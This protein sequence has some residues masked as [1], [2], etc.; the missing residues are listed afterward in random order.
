MLEESL[1]FIENASDHEQSDNGEYNANKCPCNNIH[2]VVKIITYPC[3]RNPKRQNYDSKLNERSEK[4]DDS[5]DSLDAASRRG[6]FGDSFE[7]CLEI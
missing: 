3:Q 1:R 7:S 5:E 6:D 4:L 2:R